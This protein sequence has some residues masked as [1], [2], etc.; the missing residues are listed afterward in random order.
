[1]C[2][3]CLC[4]MDTEVYINY[5]TAAQEVVMLVLQLLYLL[6]LQLQTDPHP[7]QSMIT[8]PLEEEQVH[9]DDRSSPRQQ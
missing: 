1:M 4:S 7:D 2:A 5:L 3:L 6:V 9:A 8:D